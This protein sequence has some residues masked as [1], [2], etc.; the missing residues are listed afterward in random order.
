MSASGLLTCI[1]CSVAF[2]EA[3]AQRDHY[4]TD[5]HRYNLKRKVAEFPPVSENDFKSRMNKHEEQRKALSG[6]TKSATGYC[7]ACSKSF[8]TEK[9]YENHLK[10]KKH[11]ESLK[12]FNAKENKDEIEKNRRNRKL[13]EGMEQ[14][15]VDP[16]L[17]SLLRSSGKNARFSNSVKKISKFYINE[18]IH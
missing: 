8:A 1:T 6:E 10:S 11:L 17:F 5:W 4:K 16:A 13:T 9:A 18:Q 15:N 12:N 3:S 14:V 2:K 7:V